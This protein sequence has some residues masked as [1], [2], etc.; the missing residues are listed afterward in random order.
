VRRFLIFPAALV[1]AACVS[2]SGAAPV[3]TTP[4]SSLEKRVAAVLPTPDE[5]RWLQIPW[6]TNIVEALAEA[7]R[8]GKPVMLWVMNGNPLGCA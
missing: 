7:R 3:E 8:V 5:E 1:L 4:S 6:R 2:R